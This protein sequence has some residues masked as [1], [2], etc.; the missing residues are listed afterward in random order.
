MIKKLQ[1]KFV[2]LSMSALLLVLSVIII[3]LNVANYLGVLQ[4]AD[5][6]LAILAENKGSF[7]QGMKDNKF[8]FKE[9][10]QFEKPDTKND[11]PADMSPETPYETRYFSVLLNGETH[12]VVQTETSRIISIDISD[13]IEYAQTA[14]DQ[15]KEK[16]FVEHFRYKAFSE[17]ENI[18]IVFLDCGRKLDSF[19]NVLFISFGISILGYAIVC[20]LIAFFS[21]RI[22]RPISESYE[23]QKR[24]ITDAGHEIKT[25]ITIINADV[26]VL[27]M[28]LGKNEWL[29][30]I[31][32]QVKRL[33]TLTNDLVYL[34]RM[35]ETE[36]SLQMIEFPVSDIIS[37]AA[38]SFQML[39]QA[40]N[41]KLQCNIEPMLSL[42]GNEK[43]I[44]QLTGILLDNALKYSPEDSTITL[45]LEKQS[46]SLRLTVC[47]MTKTVIPKESLPLLF[48]RF[49]RIDSS[50]NSQ[51]GGYGIGLSVAKAI[52]EN[53]KGKIQAVSQDGMTLKIVVILPAS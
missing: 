45:T 37:E 48:E 21:N 25:P 44:G 5:T 42:Y 33:A 29:E 49:Y 32:K 14:L 7:P 26:D 13:A 24:F 46:K 31:Q 41:K 28:E 36:T 3:S 9:M 47:N 34:A 17:E 18:R 11:L 51:T 43:A 19:K 53:H 38:S 1:T 40:Q 16:G 15:G 52:V 39:A 50:H 20:F 10:E 8:D 27:E 4:D 23:K 22:V 12:A 6:V 30:D 2:I 35:E